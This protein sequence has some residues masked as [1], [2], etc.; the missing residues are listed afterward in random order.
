[1]F[2]SLSE[3]DRWRR[4]LGKQLQALKDA[5][6]NNRK[7][8]SRD[9]SLKKRFVINWARVLTSKIFKLNKYLKLNKTLEM[10]YTFKQ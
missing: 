4:L 1:M 6:I 8:R 3:I 10:A 2:T 5:K 7:T 9:K